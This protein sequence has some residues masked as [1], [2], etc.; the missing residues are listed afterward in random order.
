ML[1]ISGGRRP[2]KSIFY[3]PASGFDARWRVE[4]VNLAEKFA[5]FSE[6]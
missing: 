3:P 2:Q 6:Q 1:Y 4:K 5:R